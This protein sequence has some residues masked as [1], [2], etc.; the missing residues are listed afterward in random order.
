MSYEINQNNQ[1]FQITQKRPAFVA[2]LFCSPN[3][4]RTYI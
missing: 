3:R 2:S 1:I 4:N